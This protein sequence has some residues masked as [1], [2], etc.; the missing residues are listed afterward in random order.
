MRL[1]NYVP[2]LECRVSYHHDYYVQ[3]G[4]WDGSLIYNDEIPNAIQVGVGDRQNQ[5]Y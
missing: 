1:P 4:T 3:D 2:P 5:V